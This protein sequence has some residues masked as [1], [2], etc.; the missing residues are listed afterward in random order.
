M[1]TL[2][3]PLRGEFVWG[4]VT[5]G[6]RSSVA[7]PGAN[8]RCASGACSPPYCGTTQWDLVEGQQPAAF[9][10]A[11]KAAR[12]RRTPKRKRRSMPRGSSDAFFTMQ[13]I[14]ESQ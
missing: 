9:A 8:F 1:R 3:P 5:P 12:Q 11:S 13:S 7:R 6:V 4:W 14:N 10:H 2:L